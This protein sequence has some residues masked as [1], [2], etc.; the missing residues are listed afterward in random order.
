M[1]RNLIAL[2]GV[3]AGGV[4]V[5]SIGLAVGSPSASASPDVTSPVTSAVALPTS[6]STPIAPPVAVSADNYPSIA[7]TGLSAS[8]STVPDYALSN[9]GHSVCTDL[10]HGFTKMQEVAAVKAGFNTTGP[11]SADPLTDYE[12]GYLVGASA[13]YC[14]W[15]TADRAY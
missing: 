15:H 10:D 8:H 4:L 11:G 9:L 1:S 5:F 7:R 2:A 13:L 6:V 14:P 12:A 3:L